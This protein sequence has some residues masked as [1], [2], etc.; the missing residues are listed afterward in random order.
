VTV[1]LARRNLLANTPRLI[2]SAAGIAFA[3]LLMTVEIGLRDAFLES[4][5]ITPRALDG[6]IML[7]NP[8]KYQ[9][10]RPAQVSWRQLYQARAVPGVAT[11]RP[12]YMERM[13]PIWKNPQ[14][15]HLFRITAYGF[16]PEQPVF[17]FPD[18][19]AKLEALRQPDTV[20]MDRRARSFLGEASAGTETELA[21]RHVKVVGTFRLGPNFFAD[22][23]VIM[24]DRNFFKLFGARAEMKDTDRPDIEIGVIK[25]LPGFDIPEVKHA[26][27][28]ALPSNVAVLT[29][30]ELIE[31]EIEFNLKT[32][33]IGPIFALGTI[34]G[35]AVGIMISYQILFSEL[36]DQRSQYATLKAMGYQNRYLMKVVLQQAIFYAVVGYIPAWLFGLLV[37]WVVG[38]LVLLPLRMSFELTATTFAL[39]VTMCVVSALIAVR[40]VIASDPA[41]LF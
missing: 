3:V 18:V 30:A 6:D 40:R 41:E 15:Q 4:M 13:A 39:T 22:G 20:M 12:V 37:F 8:T 26:L 35:F 32:S 34:V 36:S 7:V 5:V 38:E 29:K 28:A 31:E 19:S 23:N 24:S 27:R 10:D 9:F 25:V 21:R 33:P 11:A 2:R 17:L 14:D 1:P 16:D